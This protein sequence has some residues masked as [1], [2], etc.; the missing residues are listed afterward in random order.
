MFSFVVVEKSRVVFSSVAPLCPPVV[1]TTISWADA[2]AVGTVAAKIVTMIP[3]ASIL[4]SHVAWSH[5]PVT[6]IRDLSLAYRPAPG[7]F[8]VF[9]LTETATPTQPISPRRGRDSS[10]LCLP[11]A[12]AAGIGVRSNESGVESLE[13]DRRA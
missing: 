13:V 1:S 9:V 11:V 6:I 2:R 12:Y 7:R 10:D 3:L 8:L 4:R 5:L